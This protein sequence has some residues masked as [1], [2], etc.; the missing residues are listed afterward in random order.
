M[1]KPN[2]L[3]VAVVWAFVV[4]HFAA[5]WATV[6]DVFNDTD[7]AMRLVEVRDFLAG[8]G[9]FD[10]RQ[11]RLDPPADL[12]MH[13]SRLVDLPIA[14]LIRLAE[15][16]VPTAI[17]EK[18]AMYL[19]PT[20][21][22]VPALLAARR[23]ACRIGGDWAALPA[24]YLTA[25]CA[26]VIG[27]FVPGRID[28]H[29]VQIALTLWLLATLFEPP[30]RRRGVVAAVL[31]AVM[32]AVGMETLPFVA[33]A[34]FV[35]ALHWVACEDADEA[36]AYGLALATATVATMV[37]TQPSRLWTLGACDALSANYLA[38]AVVGGIGLAGGAIAAPSGRAVRL[39]FLAAVGGAA[40]FA[41]A[42]PEPACLRGP[43]GQI[44]P[45][46]RAVWLDGVTEVQP[47][48]VFFGAHRVDATVALL[49]PLLA[50]AAVAFLASDP[51]LR[52]STPFWALAAAAGFATLVGLGQ[53]RTIVYAD[54]LSLPLIAAAIGR[55]ARASEIEGRSA[56]VT[57]L[58][59]TVFASSSLATFVVGK[60]APASWTAGEAASTGEPGATATTPTGAGAGAS[61]MTA[62]SYADLARQPPGLVAAEI[63]LGPAIL[64]GTPHSVVTAPYHRMQRGIL[65][66]DRIL[67]SKPDE[68][69][70]VIDLRRV[71]YVVLCS[72][73]IL[74]AAARDSE[75]QSLFVAL[76]EGRIPSRLE[77]I[78]GKGVIRVFRVLP[79]TAY[80]HL[81]G[82]LS[83]ASPAAEAPAALTSD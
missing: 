63:N 41:F 15:L 78:G 33:L 77:E 50:A 32:M 12:P 45:A 74:G 38:L 37:A 4:T 35:V 27:Q 24:V 21:V 42:L 1:L 75:P 2:A 20:L 58:V 16:V 46:V 36:V 69:M 55:A 23:I 66:G 54:M 70:A 47:W 30:S 39:A 19:W 6:G 79:A 67:R 82:T 52:R 5:T 11:Y 81:R 61:C 73:S 80:A 76:M 60:L 44:L 34:A 31:S 7:D 40:V 10:L 51:G 28:H 8:Q 48:H 22:L 43:F 59:A 53:V 56:T 72:T 3:V 26:P 57:V 14:L 25:T 49:V 18:F 71:D 62:S 17:A 83:F 64:A 68:A 9:W 13:W 29:N 65:D